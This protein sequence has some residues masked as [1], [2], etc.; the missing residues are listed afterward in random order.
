M[1]RGKDSII[2][3]DRNLHVGGLFSTA[4]VHILEMQ[5]VDSVLGRGR[6]E[7]QKDPGFV[8]EIEDDHTS[9]ARFAEAGKK[10]GA[11]EFVRAHK[12][13]VDSTSTF[14]DDSGNHASPTGSE[15]EKGRKG[16]KRNSNFSFDSFTID[17]DEV[18]RA[19]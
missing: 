2:T 6:G 7:G 13:E 4:D 1:R 14:L 19:E 17:D 8:A 16:L 3:F 15:R 18:S 5:P 12:E 9:M 10:G 11:L